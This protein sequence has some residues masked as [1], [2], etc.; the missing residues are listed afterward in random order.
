M[1]LAIETDSMLLLVSGQFH[2]V[3][4]AVVIHNKD[5]LHDKNQVTLC[6]DVI[7]CCMIKLLCNLI[8][9]PHFMMPLVYWLHE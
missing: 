2:M 5:I 4:R 7:G 9:I 1:L 8:I 3:R 6:F